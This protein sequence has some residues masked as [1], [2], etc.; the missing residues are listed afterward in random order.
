MGRIVDCSSCCNVDKVLS[1][2]PCAKNQ[3]NQ[4]PVEGGEDLGFIDGLEL[5]LDKLDRKKKSEQEASSIQVDLDRCLDP[6]NFSRVD[7][8]QALYEAI[9]RNGPK[10]LSNVRGRIEGGR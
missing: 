9:G 7:E 4:Q 10:E 8:D 2:G 3:D 5:Y 6:D 1:S